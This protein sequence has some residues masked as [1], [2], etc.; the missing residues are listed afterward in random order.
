[1]LWPRIHSM[2]LRLK[3]GDLSLE[4]LFVSLQRLKLAS[5]PFYQWAT[6][7]NDGSHWPVS[8]NPRGIPW[9]C[10]GCMKVL[11]RS[12][13]T[14]VWIVPIPQVDNLHYVIGVQRMSNCVDV[15]SWYVSLYLL[16]DWVVGNCIEG[17]RL[18]WYSWWGSDYRLWDMRSKWL[19]RVAD[20]LK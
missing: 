13:M 12:L 19:S 16:R 8:F 5:D 15:A 11:T 3:V 6:F 18:R 4:I 7:L 9:S 1:M 17:E 20:L 2:H 10:R 14:S